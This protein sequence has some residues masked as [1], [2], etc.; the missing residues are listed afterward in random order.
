MPHSNSALAGPCVGIAVIVVRPEPK[1]GLPLVLLGQRV[2]SHGSGTWGLPGGKLSPGES[3]EACA[4]RELFEETGL[5]AVDPRFVTLTNDVMPADGK[6][7]VT[8]FYR[9]ASPIGE[10]RRM[11]PAK[12]L[13]WGWYPLSDLPAP[14]FEPLRRAVQENPDLFTSLGRP[15]AA[16]LPA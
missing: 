9:V 3:I 11:E 10:P 15:G 5:L 6:H 4:L 13:A 7:F 2:G 12:A 16:T 8:L 1:T 14:L